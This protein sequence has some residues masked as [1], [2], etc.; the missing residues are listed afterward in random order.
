MTSRWW[1]QMPVMRQLVILLR[2][3]SC[4]ALERQCACASHAM[5]M[6]HVSRLQLRLQLHRLLLNN[7][8]FSIRGTAIAALLADLQSRRRHMRAAPSRTAYLVLASS[9]VPG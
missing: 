6:M 2:L 7:L 8:L 1:L 4:W 9:C 5:P 3:P